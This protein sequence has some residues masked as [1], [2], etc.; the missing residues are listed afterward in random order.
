MAKTKP[1]DRTGKS[2]KHGKGSQPS[3]APKKT[4]TSPELLLTQATA[5]LQTSQPDEALVCAR[6][7]LVLLQPTL[8]PTVASLPALNLLGEINVEL[9]DV[10]AARENFTLAA[11]L[12]PEGEIPGT[13]G[14]G[15]EKFLW[16][17]QLCEEGGSE[18]VQWFEK[19]VM[20]LR[21]EIGELE[22]K[23]STPPV[24]QA[25]EEKKTKLAN[26]LCGAVEV[27]M[28]DLSYVQNHL[29]VEVELII[30]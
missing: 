12:D 20:V 25:L 28:T 1:Q 9:G 3:G 23:G 2:K 21:K 24:I 16:L 5:L 11:S 6:R 29:F 17:A 22:G 15:A 14:G 8:E 4:K 13:L 26:A 30:N 10:E 7:A 27:Y 19:G 18:S